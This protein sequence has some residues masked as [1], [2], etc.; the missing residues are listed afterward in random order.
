MAKTALI[1]MAAGIGSRYGGLKQID[2]VGPGGEKLIDYSIFDALRAGFDR[3]VF[4]IRRDIE[5]DFREH[6][7]RTIEAR[8][9]TAY[10]F[11][12]LADLPPGFAVPAGRTRPWG[13][14]HAVLASAGAVDSPFAVI[15]GDDFYGRGAFRALHD[16]LSTARG[17]G[18]VAEY[19]LV[20]YRLANTLSEHGTV[21]RG[22]CQVTPDGYLSGIRERLGIERAGSAARCLDDAGRS[23]TLALDSIVSL[24]TWGFTPGFHAEL[25][26]LFRRFL[27]AHGTEQKAEFYLPEAVGTLI[28]EGKARARVLPCEEHWFGITYREDKP[29]VV[30]AV[31]RMVA[32][33]VYPERLWS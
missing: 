31:R 5:S 8:V 33:G 6:I 21:A 27:E 9:D 28:G 29:R 23:M 25:R 17:A 12:E 2:P 11:Q 20:G 26:R 13:T 19:G 4:V 3:V 32:E 22:V 15:N 7:G 16:F 14:G 30:D 18:P 1:V 10:A 24:N